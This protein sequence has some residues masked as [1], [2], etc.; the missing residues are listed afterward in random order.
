M[1][2]N[3]RDMTWTT[4]DEMQFIDDRVSLLRGNDRTEWLLDYRT[5]CVNRKV[6]VHVSQN[7]VLAHLDK[8]LGR[9]GA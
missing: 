6:W 9:V 8:L 3:K 7:R 5:C 1:K 2:V 4:L